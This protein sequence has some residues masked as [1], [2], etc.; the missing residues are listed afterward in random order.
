MMP[1]P[2]Q[3]R[4]FSLIELMC[5][6]VIGSILLLA[7]AALLGS[8]GDGYE[9]VGGAV[10]A[11][12]EA[13]ALISQLTS[14][15]STARFHKHGVMKKSSTSWPA[16]TLGFLSLQPAQAQAEDGRIGD[17]CAVNYALR[18]LTIEGRTVRCMMRG[19]RESKD[20]FKA[21][22]N[23]SV[24]ALF[25]EQPG[26]DEPVAFAVVSFEATPKSLDE[27]GEW[28]DWVKDDKVGPQAL[29]V[30]LVIA[31]RDLAAKLKQPADW[32]GE[33]N[34]GK[35][36]GGPSQAERNKSLEVYGVLIRFGND[37]NP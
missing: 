4:G 9:R 31:R 17:L 33:G 8:S 1:P 26:L 7:A 3:F 35:L 13:R 36:L 2:R 37:E 30:R 15:L 24:A 34:A 16:D 32:D 11:E 5:S 21:L 28:V 6:M 20:T 23:D 25:T 22:E 10:S 27:D 18:D 29:D 19:F 12:R 14:D